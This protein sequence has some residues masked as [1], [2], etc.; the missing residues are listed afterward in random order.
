M[1]DPPSTTNLIS[2]F[3]RF[4]SARFRKRPSTSDASKSI[5]IRDLWST[6]LTRTR[7]GCATSTT[8]ERPR[9]RFSNTM[10]T[11]DPSLSLRTLLDCSFQTQSL[12]RASP[13]GSS[14]CHRISI[15]F[16]SSCLR[17]RCA[18][19]WRRIRTAATSRQSR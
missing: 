7:G 16:C 12:K 11:S 2:H 18:R 13:S 1:D 4:C 9:W 3:Q 14:T 6:M 10:V 17:T 8:S 5:A 15:T 19:S